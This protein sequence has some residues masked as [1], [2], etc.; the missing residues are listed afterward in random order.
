MDELDALE[1]DLATETVGAG[2][3]PAYL[4]ASWGSAWS[5][6][7]AAEQGG[8]VCCGHCVCVG[9]GGLLLLAPA[10]CWQWPAVP[11]ALRIRGGV[12]ARFLGACLPG[13]APRLNS[14]HML[15]CACCALQDTELPE[16]PAGQPQAQGQDEFGLPAVPQRT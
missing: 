2:S 10:A 15:C 5:G 14:Q 12:H 3:V 13:G 6:A 8:G 1:D 16:V 9:G 11:P 4:Q 7:G